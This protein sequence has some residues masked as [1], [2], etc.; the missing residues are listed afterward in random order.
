MHRL[1]VQRNMT[2]NAAEED[3]PSFEQQFGILANAEITDKFPQLDSMKLAFQLIDKTDDNTKAVGASVYIVGKTVIFVPAFFRN[4]Q[5]KTGD[6]MLIGQ[7]QTFLPL[8]DPWLAWIKNK[9]LAPEGELVSAK[10]MDP[11]G[12]TKGTTIREIADPIM[13]TASQKLYPSE[14]IPGMYFWSY[15]NGIEKSAK[16]AEDTM[17][18]SPASMSSVYLKGLCKLD[19]E[20]TKTAAQ[21]N[22]F[23]TALHMGKEA[24]ASMLDNMTKTDL[25]NAT[26]SFYNPEELQKFAYAAQDMDEPP[27]FKVIMPFEKEAK[28]LSGKELNALYKDGFFIKVAK[29]GNVPKVIRKQKVNN[30]FGMLKEPGKTSLLQPDG[31]LREAYIAKLPPSTDTRMGA[32]DVNS[33]VA[34]RNHLNEPHPFADE[35]AEFIAITSDGISYARSG[36]MELLADRKNLDDAILSEIGEPLKGKG[37]MNSRDA[38]DSGVLFVYPDGTCEEIYSEMKSVGDN[39]WSRYNDTYQL[40]DEKSGLIRPLVTGNQVLVPAGTRVVEFN[41]VG[42]PMVTMATLES[43]IENY[44]QKHY[45]KARIYNN[46]SEYTVSGDNTK[47]ANQMLSF[48]EAALALVSDYGV[49]PADAKVMLKDAS[50]GATYDNPRSTTYMI[51]KIAGLEDGTWEDANIP[52]DKHIN[53]PPQISQRELPTFLEDP[54]QLEKAVTTAA[55]NGIK[56]V[57]DVT[58]LKLLVKQNRFFD[59]IQEDLPVFMQVLDSLCRKL[60]QFYWHTEKM[61]EKYGMVKLKSLEESIKVTLD[62]LSELTIFFKLRT[63]DG[64]GSTGDTLGDLMSGTML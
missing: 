62:S 46:G 10:D 4:G 12:T 1:I 42:M 20:L 29:E 48:K 57:F 3:G 33:Y 18:D 27:A 63:V 17:K 28:E 49:A 61:E 25:L 37:T 39:T 24:T 51:E 54:A 36:V 64:T 52:M 7:S 8:S 50:N 22:V 30:L 6:M 38:K 55:Q 23:D 47:N 60:F 13:K 41:K 58:I 26:L 9:D 31:T 43:F 56:E 35:K 5:L 19:P 11:I 59:E 15:V 2:K 14:N 40:A 45:K 16:L 32:N 34:N 53:R 21:M 44:T